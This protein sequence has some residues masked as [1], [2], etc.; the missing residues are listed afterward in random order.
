MSALGLQRVLGLGSYRTAWTCLHRLRHAMVRPSRELLGGSVEVDETVVGGRRRGRGQHLD[1]SKGWV[2]VAV[3]IRGK[4]SGRIRLAL[5]SGTSA[6]YLE[7]FVQQV[8]APGSEV[9]TD[10]R[11]GYSK[12]P[13]L[14][15]GYRP[16]KLMNM[17]RDASERLFPRVH[18]VAALL[19]RWLLGIHQGRVSRKHLAAYLNEFTFRFNRRNSPH[20]GML[21]YR[22]A[23]QAVAIEPLTS[24]KGS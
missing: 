13:E 5:L 17:D 12:L 19:K 8:V 1:E 9:V 10:G 20:R 23:Q 2:G 18:R 22:L 6:K 21:F 16:T 4:G 24:R 15:Y 7:G 14:G 11:W 3:E